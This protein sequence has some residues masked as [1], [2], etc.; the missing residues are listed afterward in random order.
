MR[1]QL[2]LSNIRKSYR[3]VSVLIDCTYNFDNTGVYVIMG[4]NGSGK[5]TLLRIAALLESP[6]YG[7]V[8]YYI[9]GVLQRTDIQ[10]KRRITIVLP[11]IG[12]FNTS[13]Y[14]NVAFGLKIRGLRGKEL[15]ER[16]R[17][18]L[19][20]V[21]LHHKIKQNALT[22]SSGE[23]QRLGI[24]RAIAINPA[25]LFLDEPT[26]FIDEEN[27]KV[28]ED[29]I[30]QL[31]DDKKSTIIMTTHDKNQAE[32]LGDFIL[33]LNKGM[34]FPGDKQAQNTL[35]SSSYLENI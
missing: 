22:L 31:K 15:D 30:L 25:F 7:S 9:N 14:T 21:G 29:I 3:N 23:T 27:T 20:F 18:V 13:V 33:L 32:R 26:S 4:K 5:S 17:D 8:E 34:L 16:V 6:N 10:L 35:F 19:S 24:A 28:I 11:K 12:V 1:L 2:R